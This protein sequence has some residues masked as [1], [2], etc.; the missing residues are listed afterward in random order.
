MNGLECCTGELH[1]ISAPCLSVA[2]AAAA[3]AS[4]SSVRPQ[5]EA[6]GRSAS[7]R[8]KEGSR[9]QMVTSKREKGKQR[10]VK[11]DVYRIEERGGRTVL[12]MREVG[13]HRE[14]FK[15]VVPHNETTAPTNTYQTAPVVWDVS[16]KPS[17]LDWRPRQHPLSAI[18]SSS[19]MPSTTGGSLFAGAAPGP[20]KGETT[21]AA[22]EDTAD[23][24]LPGAPSV[25]ALSGTSA[26]EG[27][28][29]S[30]AA[31]SGGGTSSLSTF[32]AAIPT[33]KPS[34]DVFN[35]LSGAPS[36][37]FTASPTTTTAAPADLFGGSSFAPAKGPSTAQSTTT[38]ISSPF[39]LGKA[40]TGGGGGNLFCGEAAASGGGSLVGD[41]GSKSSGTDRGSL[42]GQGGAATGTA[43]MFDP[44]SGSI[45]GGTVI[46]SGSV[47][48]E[49]QRPGGAAQGSPSPIHTAALHQQT[50]I[51][52]DCS[53]ED[54]LQFWGSMMA[55]EA[56]HLGKRLINLTALTLVQPFLDQSW[57][58][59][60][61]IYV[62]EAM[63]AVTGAV[64]V[65]SELADRG[66]KMPALERVELWGWG[67]DQLGRFISSS[68]SLKE[69]GG[70]QRSW[71]WW[72]AVFE[73]FPIT[74]AG[75]PG[76]LRHLQTIGGIASGG[77]EG[78]K[79]RRLQDVLTSRGCHKSLTSLDV[80]I[81][82]FE[83]RDSLSA[84]LAVD[85]F[86]NDYCTSPDVPLT[87]T[88]VCD[89]FF[90]LSE[91]YADMF[92]P[93]PSP[94][95]KTAIK[96]AARQAARVVY[97][98]SQHDITHPL[99]SP[100]EA[101]IDI[102]QSLTFDK[103]EWVS[104]HNADGFVP[105]PG[106]PSPV[107]TIINHLQPFPR[108]GELCV[109]S[110]L[111]VATGRLLAEKMPIQVGWVVFDEAV[112]AQ[113]RIGVLEGLGAGREV[114]TVHVG[115]LDAVS[116]KQG[117][118]FDGW[119]SSRLP[120][121]GEIC[122]FLEVSDELEPLAAAEFIRS[123]LSTLLTA[124]VR[125]LRRVVVLLPM[126]G[127]LHDAIRELCPN[128][129]RVGGFTINTRVY[130]GRIGLMATRDP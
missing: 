6:M 130:D 121:I 27:S 25:S 3:A 47:A 71:E 117:G 105:P 35:G 101:A 9:V 60:T 1:S 72:A 84:L 18:T 7:S 126:H 12:Y 20:L 91:F 59:N 54:D 83:K 107:P 114:R 92:P 4:S 28:L 69:V 58:L 51:A 86:I 89:E 74:S 68:Q 10:W 73:H 8:Y 87:V 40:S 17:S 19:T 109:D 119:G 94:F 115:A 81:P 24:V 104:V 36:P 53:N 111:S 23:G 26:G 93:R 62:V 57:C 128:G 30:A 39:E 76:P 95:I 96:E 32:G 99:D 106:S 41:V 90:E 43:G 122:M 33:P 13:G 63:R 49:Q 70:R 124:G 112:S 113:D 100:S 78:D 45:T 65:H 55:E 77:I 37:S 98:I 110:R 125:G 16:K 64:G 79:V 5:A 67:A 61:M 52:I 82:P 48:F 14:E 80:E 15:V 50:H 44:F 97:T 34:T 127:R 21:A 129:T 31:S 11:A 103:V 38:P 75:Q 116:L 42:P 88:A 22:N 120:S 118:V 2:M 102:A 85:D 66:W 108:V 46:L 29:S 56:F 123:G